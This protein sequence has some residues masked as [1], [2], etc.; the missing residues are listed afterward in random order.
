MATMRDWRQ[1]FDPDAEFVYR[2]RRK[3]AHE[4]SGFTEPGAL[5]SEQ[6]RTALGAHKLKMWWRAGWIQLA[7]QV[8]VKPLTEDSPEQAIRHLGAGWYDV[9]VGGNVVRCRTLKKA[10]EILKGPAVENASG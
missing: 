5:V 1:T 2:K 3:F 4:P 8:K 6:A 9:T 10:H 7:D